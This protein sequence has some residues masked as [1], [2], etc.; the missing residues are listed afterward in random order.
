LNSYLDKVGKYNYHTTVLVIKTKN[1]V[2]ENS[3]FV[4]VEFE[5]ID[6]F[7]Y[8]FKRNRSILIDKKIV[9]ILLKIWI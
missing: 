4:I 6:L 1:I 5:S 7:K 8:N 9:I 3:F 2:Y